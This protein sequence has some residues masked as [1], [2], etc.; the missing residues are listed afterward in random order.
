MEPFQRL[1]RLDEPMDTFCDTFVGMMP[2]FFRDYG[3][4]RTREQTNVHVPD[5]HDPGLQT[6][7]RNRHIFPAGLGARGEVGDPYEFTLPQLLDL[8]T[9][10]YSPETHVEHIFVTSAEYCKQQ[11][12]PQHEF[13]ILKVEDAGDS[14]L[15]NYLLLDRT[16]DTPNQ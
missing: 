16:S 2:Q 15:V 10:N 7:P 14:R 6:L 13:I 11:E 9:R 8:M 4:T 12:D 5:V 3:R 1:W